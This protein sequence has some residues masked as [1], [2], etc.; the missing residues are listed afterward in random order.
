MLRRLCFIGLLTITC[1]AS[2]ATATD[3]ELL[4]TYQHEFG[5]MEEA[6]NAVTLRVF[7]DGIVEVHYPIFMRLAGDYRYQISQPELEN[8][9]LSLHQLGVDQFDADTTRQAL[10]FEKRAAFEAA[11]L[12][13]QTV[14][15]ITDADLTHLQVENFSLSNT[16]LE[17]NTFS[18]VGVRNEAQLYPQVTALQELSQALEL[19]DTLTNDARMQR[20]E[21]IQ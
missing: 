1:Y 3:A 4:L 16:N 7:K 17:S 21:V 9:A 6:D 5:L 10:A 14:N 20:I 13:G 12:P 18:F 19:L 2:A 8:L 11:Q 15:F